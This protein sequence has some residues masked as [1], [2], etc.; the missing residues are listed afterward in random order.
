[1]PT[2]SEELFESYCSERCY[3]LKAIS[4]ASGVRTPDYRLITV[5]CEIICEVKQLEPNEADK[6]V[7]EQLRGTSTASYS[8]APGKRAKAAIRASK[9]Q[10]KRS[11]VEGKPSMLVVYDTTCLGHLDRQLIE[12]AMFG[13]GI[14]GVQMESKGPVRVL[15]KHR[16]FSANQRNYISAIAV[17]ERRQSRP[18]IIVYHNPYAEHPIPNVV[19]NDPR[20]ENVYYPRG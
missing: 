5:G 10:L 1:M 11:R 13:L 6:G 7:L 18:R 15:A 2:I 8:L 9:E 14:Y 4:T 17:L 3:G 12:S 20:D 16:E 19:F